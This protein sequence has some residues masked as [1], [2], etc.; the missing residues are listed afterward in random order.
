[1]IAG[2]GRGDPCDQRRAAERYGRWAE[3]LCALALR[4][5]GYRILARDLRTP[6][7]EIDLIARRGR[8]IAFIE[9]KA[10][11]EAAGEVLTPRQRRRIVRT[12]E[13]FLQNHRALAAL[14]LRFDV[15]LVQRRRW[16]THL[17]AA[18]RADD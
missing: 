17:R 11:A 6:V 1:M 5:R 4:L 8:V 3:S 18:F 10:R 9:V 13:L 14:D 2:T 12:A 7:G 15:M 16:P